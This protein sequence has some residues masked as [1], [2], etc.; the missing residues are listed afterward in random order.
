MGLI[1]NLYSFSNNYSINTDVLIMPY[2]A[3]LFFFQF[4]FTPVLSSELLM[5]EYLYTATLLLNTFVEQHW[6]R[7][8]ICITLQ[9]LIEYLFFERII[10]IFILGNINMKTLSNFKLVWRTKYG[11]L[12][13]NRL[14]IQSEISIRKILFSWFK[15]S[16]M[17][18]KRNE[19]VFHS[20]Q[21][22][23]YLK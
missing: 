6:L 15:I 11:Q 2:N 17:N 9:E 8:M 1:Q 7:Y 23:F 10:A 12:I 22:E 3:D 21:T 13:S 16:T 5:N 18:T 14:Q 4:R 20:I 19:K